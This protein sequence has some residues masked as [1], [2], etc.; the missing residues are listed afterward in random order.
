MCLNGAQF[1]SSD[2]NNIPVSSMF[3]YNVYLMPQH[4]VLFQ[5]LET[6]FFRDPLRLS[7]VSEGAECISI[8]KTF[9]VRESNIN[10]LKAAT[11]V[12]SN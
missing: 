3:T 4:A 11:D 7:L 5:G 2:V 9:F 1:I 6:I 8:S 10:V 12:V